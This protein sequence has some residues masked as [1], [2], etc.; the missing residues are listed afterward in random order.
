MSF[1]TISGRLQGNIS[2][3]RVVLMTSTLIAT[4]QDF[5]YGAMTSVRGDF[6]ASS[7]GVMMVRR[8][9]LTAWIAAL[10]ASAHKASDS[11]NRWRGGLRLNT[12]SLLPDFPSHCRQSI[13]RAPF[14]SK[15]LSALADNNRANRKSPGRR[16]DSNALSKSCSPVSF[17]SLGVTARSSSAPL[18]GHIRTSILRQGNQC[19][20]FECLAAD[21]LFGFARCQALT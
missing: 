16:R 1:L 13:H 20:F 6:S 21:I 8:L 9:F 17:P 3:F 7:Q 14:F 5:R 19:L 10:P 18:P 2:I 12:P 15:T 4:C 11:S